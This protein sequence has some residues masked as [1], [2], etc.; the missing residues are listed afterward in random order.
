M[1]SITLAQA[2][3]WILAAIGVFMTIDKFADAVKKRTDEIHEPDRAQEAKI[4]QLQ[5]AMKKAEERLDRHDELFSADLERFKTLEGS[6]RMMLRAVRALLGAQLSG[7]NV[8]ALQKSSEEID[9]YLYE[10]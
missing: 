8:D 7:D 9:D 1:G 2:G 6:N 5:L 3:A 4:A 10:R